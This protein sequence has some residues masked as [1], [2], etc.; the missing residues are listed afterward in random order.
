V[1]NTAPK[2]TEVQSQGLSLLEIGFLY[3]LVRPHR[4]LHMFEQLLHFV[5]PRLAAR[6]GKVFYS[7]RQAFSQPSDLYVLGLNPGGDPHAN[8]EETVASHTLQVAS[9]LP[10]DWSA[11]RDESW[12]GSR[13][14]TW[15]MQPGVLHMFGALGIQPGGVPCSN[16]VFPRSR[17]AAELKKEL[18]SLVEM[19]WPFHLKVIELVKPKAIVCFGQDAGKIVCQLLSA[20][21]L[22]GEFVESNFRG[23][24]SRAF[25]S[26]HGPR[27]I[28]TTHPSRADW[29]NPAA[30]PTPLIAATLN[31][32]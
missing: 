7:G 28:V 10:A 20:G 25:K 12:E 4:A 5:P 17:S 15:G 8:A 3:S 13:P 6:S 16:L 31:E 29:R 19:C 24:K 21:E 18:P 27:V 23:W 14:G 30:D 2:I 1:K 26:S 9:L 22:C 11:Y 32:T